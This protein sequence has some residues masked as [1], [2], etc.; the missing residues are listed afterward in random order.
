[1]NHYTV[2]DQQALLRLISG[3]A[4]PDGLISGPIALGLAV[5]C[6]AMVLD[7]EDRQWGNAYF[8]CPSCGQATDFEGRIERSECSHCG[9]A[10]GIEGLRLSEGWVQSLDAWKEAVS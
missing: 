6:N 2:A 8:R 5:L 3:L 4:G 9:E 10:M 1:M 7:D